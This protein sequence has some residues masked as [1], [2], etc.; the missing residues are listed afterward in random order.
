MSFN[1]NGTYYLP[2]PEF[3][4]VS[5]TVI[6]AS[7]FNTIMRDVED[8]LSDTFLRTGVSTMSGDLKMG[9][10]TISG[11]GNGSTT[12]PA[13]RFQNNIDTGVYLKNTDTFVIVVD[14]V[15]VF[16]A[17]ASSVTINGVTSFGSA[18]IVPPYLI[19]NAGVY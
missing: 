13:I 16:L 8:A 17:T 11:L 12:L 6:L 14:G 7:D 10:R 9:G 3:P 15:E 5:G 1:S 4:A 2:E 18:V 19:Q